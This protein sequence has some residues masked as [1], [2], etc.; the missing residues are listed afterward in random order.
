MDKP[1]SKIV[2]LQDSKE[3]PVKLELATA[4]TFSNPAAQLNW[5]SGDAPKLNHNIVVID[6]VVKAILAATFMLPHTQ[7]RC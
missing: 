4:T 3:G 7:Q 5:E 2:P 6:R 1:N